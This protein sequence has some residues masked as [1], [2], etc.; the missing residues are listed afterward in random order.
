MTITIL[1]NKVRPRGTLRGWE[2][3]GLL[4]AENASLGDDIERL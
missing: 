1:T 2:R 4:R 3:E